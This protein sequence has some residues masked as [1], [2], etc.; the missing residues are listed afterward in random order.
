MKILLTISK[1]FLVISSVALINS[2]TKESTGANTSATGKGGSVTR[3]TIAQNYLYVVSNHFL[4]VYSLSNPATPDLVHTS[5]LNYDIETIYPYNKYLF[6]GTRT[7]LYV[8]SIDTA[9]S[10]RLI[11]QAQHARSCDPVVVNDSVAFVTLKSTGN[12][13]PAQAGL[14]IHDITNITNPVLKNTIPLPDPAGL[15]LQDSILYVCCGGAG[16]KIFNVKKPYTPILIS[17]KTDGNYLDVIPYNGMLI[18]DATDG[19]ILYDITNP[20][21]PALIKKIQ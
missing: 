10:P 5:D 3:F 4:Y 20:A 9:S 11:G 18:C 2:C 6:L 13:G 15:G 14:Y 1:S 21:S 19:I 17:S 12:C 8:Y 16:L 7:G